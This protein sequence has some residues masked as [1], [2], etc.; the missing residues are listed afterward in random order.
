M[1]WRLTER[2]VDLSR[3]ARPD[4]ADGKHFGS[5]AATNFA[6]LPADETA[7]AFRSRQVFD[8]L[9]KPPLGNGGRAEL[10][11]SRVAGAMS[12]CGL[13]GQS[14]AVMYAMSRWAPTGPNGEASALDLDAFQFAVERFSLPA[15]LQRQLRRDVE[16]Y[17]GRRGLRSVHSVEDLVSRDVLYDC[18]VRRSD[19]RAH[20]TTRSQT[21]R[22][23]YWDPVLSE[24]PEIDVL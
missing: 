1:T 20:V 13:D 18:G 21:D 23:K 3:T 2:L 12:M 15:R 19:E 22:S 4:R 6:Q 9:A 11:V 5:N 10:D 17:M 8:V 7:A 14:C 24:L 16:D